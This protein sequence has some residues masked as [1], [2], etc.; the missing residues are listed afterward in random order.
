M[1]SA[2]VVPDTKSDTL[3]PITTRKIAKDSVVY[4]DFYRSDN[5]LD[6]VVF[7]MKESTIQS[8]LV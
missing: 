4:T 3:I 8:S 7:P 2:K 6:V 5:V 1:V